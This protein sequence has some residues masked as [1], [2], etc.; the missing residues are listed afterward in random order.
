MP[1]LKVTY[2]NA[3]GRG[4]LTRLALVAGGNKFED[5][6]LD[7]AGF[8]ALKPSLPL[9]Q[10][11]VLEVDGV[12]YPQSM[13]IARYAA[14]IGGL[15][16]TDPLEALLVDTVLESVLEVNAAAAE[17]KYR[18]PDESAKA[19]KSKVLLE[20]TIPKIFG[21]IEKRIKGKTVLGEQLSLADLQLFD[22]LFNVVPAAVANWKISGYPKVEAIVEAVKTHP[23]VAAYLASH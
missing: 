3:P 4:E 16:P 19:E 1:Q 7:Y 15:Y 10:L 18:T 9:G 6:R 2:F 8:S 22:T 14:R 21:M 5:E 11:P 13:A 20:T 23:N 17:I 12:T